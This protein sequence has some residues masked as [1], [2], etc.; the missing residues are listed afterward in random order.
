[1]HIMANKWINKYKPKSACRVNF[2][3][4][5]RILP[6]CRRR[7]SECGVTAAGG[8]N[9]TDPVIVIGIVF[10][11]VTDVFHAGKL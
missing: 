2:A 10:L 1:M 4:M 7:R 3:A 6:T 8:W 9:R 5:C 11:T